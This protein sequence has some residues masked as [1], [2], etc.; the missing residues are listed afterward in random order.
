[1]IRVPLLGKSTDIELAMDQLFK[2]KWNIPQAAK[3]MGLEAKE[4]SWLKT[5]EMFSQYCKEHG[6]VWKSS[7][8]TKHSE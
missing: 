2:A 5:K 7:D 6:S 1:M 3:A 4:E 8:L